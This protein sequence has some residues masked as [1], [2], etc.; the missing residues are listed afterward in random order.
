LSITT[1]LI[2]PTVDTLRLSG[3]GEIMEVLADNG[4]RPLS[5]DNL[6]QHNMQDGSKAPLEWI[7]VRIEVSDTGYGIKAQDMSQSKLF[8]KSSKCLL[9]V[10]VVELTV[11][12]YLFFVKLRLTKRNKVVNKVGLF[13]FILHWP[14][15]EILIL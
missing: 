4:Q 10:R 5:A 7:V 15:S 13:L 12:F 11:F 6:S 1:R 8:C 9:R 3:A 2:L 14:V